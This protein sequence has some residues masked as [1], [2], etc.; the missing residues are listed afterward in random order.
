MATAVDFPESNDVLKA[1]PGTED[2]VNDLRIFRQGLSFTPNGQRLDLCV[3]SCWELS[4]EELA[5]V[6]RTK[7]IYFQALGRTHPPIMVHGSTPFVQ[8]PT[9]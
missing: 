2:A 7:R 9:E 1:A 3:V 6:I 5:E 4:D 8:L